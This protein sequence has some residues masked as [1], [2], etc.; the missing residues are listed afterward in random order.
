M[1]PPIHHFADCS[2]DP[3]ARELRRNGELVTLSP[4]VFD[5][6]AYLIEHRERAVGRDELMAAVWGRADV[7]DTLL[8]QTVLKARR[9]IGDDGNEQRMIRTVPRFG[10]RWVAELLF[11]PVHEDAKQDTAVTSPKTSAIVEPPPSAARAV[12]SA[13]QA[14]LIAPG[15]IPA[16]P[17]GQRKRSFIVVLLAGAALGA[18][19]IVLFAIRADHPPPLAPTLPD[20]IPELTAVATQDRAAVLPLDVVADPTWAWLRLGLMDLVANR[21]RSAGQPVVPSDNVVALTRS[22]TDAAAS[23]L[24]LRSAT[25]ARYVVVSRVEQ[26]ARGWHVQL[27]LREAD[28]RRRDV[29]ADNHD[30]IAAATEASDRLLVLLGRSPA[31]G[32]DTALSLT[33]LQQ[34]TEAALLSDDFPTALR[35]IEAAPVALREAPQIRLR[36]AQIEFRSGHMTQARE[37]LLTLLAQVPA[38]VDPAL[39]ARI[40]NGLGAVAMHEA[41]AADAQIA[42]AEAVALVETRQQPAIL[43]QAYTGLGIARA[44]QGQ[45]DAGSA[46]LSR[47]RVA[48]ELAGDALALGRVEAN[49]GILD[50]VRGRYAAA[51]PTLQRAV[52]RFEQFGALNEWF[53]TVGAQIEAYL[54]LLQ[55]TEALAA[56]E[57]AFAQHGRLDNPYTRD[58]MLL[59]RV[60]ALAGLGRSSDARALLSRLR[61]GGDAEQVLLR[62]Q[63]AAVEARFALL[64]GRAA[65][66]AVAAREAV[67]GLQDPDQSR[68]RA[69]AWLDLVRALQSNQQP[70]LAAD[71]AQRLAQWAG[72]SPASPASALYATLARAEQAWA[73]EDQETALHDYQQALQ[74]AEHWAVPFDLA[75][76]AAS[77]GGAL[78]D[79]GRTE[80]ASVV[81]GRIAR[82]AESDFS[83]ALLQA[84]LYRALGQHDAWQLA[85]TR[86]EGLAG[87]R[88]IPAWA[89]TAPGTTPHIEPSPAR[90]P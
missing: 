86:A 88:P 90:S 29:T 59:Q 12:V 81:V 67:Q 32:H 70:G 38:E 30:A 22:A 3:A 55:P 47:A 41:R 19:V 84:R 16:T 25:G 53:L 15:N 75:N 60:R 24:A 18:L 54:A 45:Y 1:L 36:L 80:R 5:C 46:D 37:G 9:A 69:L 42:F 52:G 40:L 58:W 39:R 7:S 34:R 56:S 71:E 20:S 61:A 33:E 11:E 66:A 85:L 57:A 68:S 48:L 2:V 28:G 6:L 79:S 13:D 50:T 89:S 63:I 83:C 4:K 23:M 14:P 44:S 10:Y 35:L 27:S 73:S 76:V 31:A 62:A 64:D 72:Q 87:E 77:Y 65:D 8:G 26:T 49:E 78:I 74:Q 82:W 51:L 17:R 21:L 43:G